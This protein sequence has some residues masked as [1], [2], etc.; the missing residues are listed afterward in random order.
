MKVMDSTGSAICSICYD[1]LKPFVSDLQAVSVCGH[2]FHELWYG[3]GLSLSLSE[4]RPVTVPILF[5]LD[6]IICV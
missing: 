2:V 3:Y 4:L 5:G 6:E 1:D